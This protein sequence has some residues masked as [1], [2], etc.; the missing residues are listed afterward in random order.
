MLQYTWFWDPESRVEY[1]YG[2]IHGIHV[3]ISIYTVIK[4]LVTDEVV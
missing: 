1:K 2:G 3:Y 4:A